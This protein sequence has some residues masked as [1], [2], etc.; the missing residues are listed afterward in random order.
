MVDA[1]TKVAITELITLVAIDKE[2]IASIMS[3]SPL[4]FRPLIILRVPLCLVIIVAEL[5]S[6][7]T[8]AKDAL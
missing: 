8:S 2:P 6:L 3:T 4:A 5:V 7:E 1:D